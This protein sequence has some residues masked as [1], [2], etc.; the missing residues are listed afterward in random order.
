[1]PPGWAFPC[2]P[3]RRGGSARR[4]EAPAALLQHANVS[5]TFLVCLSRS[6]VL[7]PPRLPVM[8]PGSPSRTGVPPHSS[9]TRSFRGVSVRMCP[10]TVS[11]TCRDNAPNSN[12]PS[13]QAAWRF[14]PIISRCRC[15]DCSRNQVSPFFSTGLPNMVSG[16][17]THR[18]FQWSSNGSSRGRSAVSYTHLTLPPIY[19]V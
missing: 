11:S 6:G 2:R 5:F 13:T 1:M 8:P 7:S 12:L 3:H 9:C 10:N 16:K 15:S 18:P 14:P 17:A 4:V 19:S